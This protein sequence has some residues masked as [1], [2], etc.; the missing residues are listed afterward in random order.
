LTFSSLIKK[1]VKLAR[2]LAENLASLLKGAG[3]E[4]SRGRGIDALRCH[5]S[6]AHRDRGSDHHL[7]DWL[8]HA[9]V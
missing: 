8:H 2:R 5:L 6:G 4:R 9:P 1:L 3:C 7:N